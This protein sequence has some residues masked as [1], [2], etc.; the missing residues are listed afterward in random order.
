MKPQGFP[1]DISQYVD[2]KSPILKYLIEIEKKHWK[3]DINQHFR[4]T[5]KKSLDDSEESIQSL[6]GVTSYQLA[7]QNS[8]ARSQ[9]KSKEHYSGRVGHLKLTLNDGGARDSTQ[10]FKSQPRSQRPEGEKRVMGTREMTKKR[11]KKFELVEEDLTHV[12]QPRI[13]QV[14]AVGPKAKTLTTLKS[15]RPIGSGD[16]N[17]EFYTVKTWASIKEKSTQQIE[18][19]RTEPQH[20]KL[21]NFILIDKATKPKYSDYS[22]RSPRTLAE[23]VSQLNNSNSKI[24]IATNLQNNSLLRQPGLIGMYSP[25]Q[26]SQVKA[27]PTILYSNRSNKK[28][29][30]E[31]SFGSRGDLRTTGLS[32]K[33]LTSVTTHNALASQSGHSLAGPQK[34]MLTSDNLK[35]N[36]THTDLRHYQ[37]KAIKQSVQ[38]VSLRDKNIMVLKSQAMAGSTILNKTQKSKE[39]SS[40]FSR[41][42]FNSIRHRLDNH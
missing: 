21:N 18:P 20:Q 9:V 41:Q 40:T 23:K 33:K 37:S 8:S 17:Q 36:L 39:L 14:E 30:L 2:L 38:L 27:K 32:T 5:G 42:L 22:T 1:R 3:S 28:S 19:K 35:T 34:H 24:R 29:K 12:R 6:R 10:G 7:G 16:F 26:S 31:A 11:P 15:L 4:L 25:K 13:G